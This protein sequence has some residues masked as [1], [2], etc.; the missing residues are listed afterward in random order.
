MNPEWLQAFVVFSQTPSLEAAARM[1]GRTQ[2]TLTRQ[3]QSLE[4]TLGVE[5][6]SM[7]GR[8]KVLT[9]AGQELASELRPRF[10]GLQESVHRALT[11]QASPENVRIHIGGRREILAI[12]S[13]QI[14]FSGQLNF[15]F[16]SHDEIVDRLFART[17]DIGITHELPDSLHIAANPIF[18]DHFHLCY[19]KSWKLRESSSKKLL[20]DL[21]KTKPY[22]AYNESLAGTK[23]VLERLNFSTGSLRILR[24]CPDWGMISEMIANDLGWSMIPEK[25]IKENRGIEVVKLSKDLQ[26]C[27]QFYLIYLKELSQFSWFKEFRQFKW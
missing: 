2:P 27:S 20:E 9:S 25:Q 12:Y 1:L 23:P 19:P 21:V 4:E 24:T 13:G 8:K 6:F 14:P 5:L 10:E 16:L 17:L 7:Q 15:H 26:V 18:S 22:L 3:L 11:R